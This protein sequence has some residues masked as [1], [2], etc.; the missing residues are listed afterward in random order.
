MYFFLYFFKGKVGIDLID[1][2][3]ALFSLLAEN[4]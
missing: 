4:V 1:D 2:S 3:F